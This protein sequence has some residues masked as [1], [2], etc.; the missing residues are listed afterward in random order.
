MYI[1]LL[2]FAVLVVLA[3]IY[4]LIRQCGVFVFLFLMLLISQISKGMSTVYLDSGT[5]NSELSNYT[6]NVYAGPIYFFYL[7]I[8]LFFTNIFIYCMNKRIV[9]RPTR[10]RYE[11]TNDA[12]IALLK[13][14][15]IL[16]VLYLGLDL[17]VS[18]IPLLSNGAITRF[19]YWS[20]YSKLP[21]ASLVSNMLTV[22]CAGIG[23][24]FASR[25][26]EAKRGGVE[27]AIIGLALIERF[28]LGYRVSGIIDILLA[29]AVGFFYRKFSLEKQTRYYLKRLF[30]YIIIG[31]IIICGS[32]IL[33]QAVSGLS[34]QDAWEKLLERQLSLSGHMEWAVFG[35]ANSKS[36][37]VNDY[38]ELL[39]VFQGKTDTDANIGVYGLMDR[40]AAT[41]TYN[42]YFD[43]GVR[44]GASFFATSLFYNGIMVTLIIL[45]INSLILS[46]FYLMFRRLAAS[47]KI[48]SFSIL[49]RIY[50]IFTSYLNSTGTLVSF[51]RTNV[52]LLVVGYVVLWLFEEM[53]QNASP[54]GRRIALLR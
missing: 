3:E 24:I 12:R 52:L 18:G 15:G 43:D 4:V 41:D 54:D 17:V 45:I 35:D 14:A 33:S 47:D 50:I 21:A 23:M 29:F 40:F 39:S 9:E 13:V 38:A 28:L 48:L 46:V 19:N 16:F 32:Y 34:L 7:A 37:W 27:I 42:H 2:F 22:I 26:T 20:E 25:G 31:L 30:V 49:F 1:G 51:Y 36:F 10:Y 11:R 6:W 8:F 44:F 53:I 5:Y